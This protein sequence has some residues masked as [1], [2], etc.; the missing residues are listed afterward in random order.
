MF[1]NN[2]DDKRAYSVGPSPRRHRLWVVERPVDAAST[3]VGE[4][5]TSWL[6]AKQSLRPSTRQSYESH[7][8]LHVVPAVGDIRLSDLSTADLEQMYAQIGS[9]VRVRPVGPATLCRIHATVLS[10]LNTAVRRGLIE[11][12]P[13][14][15]VELP[16]NRSPRP[17]VWTPEDLASFLG[18]IREDPLHLLY[19]VLGLRGLRRGEAIGLRTV[20]VDLAHK[21][22]RIEQQA[23]QVKGQLTFGPPKSRAGSR[24]VAIDEWLARQFH[25]HLCQQRLWRHKAGE[26]WREHGLVFTNKNGR[27]AQ[28]EL[29]DAPFRPPRRR[30]RVAADPAARSA[31]YL[32]IGRT[33]QRGNADRGQPQAWALL[34]RH[35]R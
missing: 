13:G 6:A 23:V 18:E 30:G 20:D 1:N 3:T 26:D 8:Q 28:P 15:A 31:P 22:L 10:A 9:Q 5:L 33:G 4:Y 2:A 24:A 21:V 14:T 34:D 19:A 16:I 25:W 32:S 11:R 29:C 35:H 17:R 27:A 7:L 12:N